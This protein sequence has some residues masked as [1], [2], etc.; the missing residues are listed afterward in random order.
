MASTALRTVRFFGTVH[1][2]VDAVRRKGAD[3]FT[4]ER[5]PAVLATT[6]V[7]G[8]LVGWQVM[9]RIQSASV[10]FGGV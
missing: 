6:C 5:F 7:T 4:P 1:A 8:L 9:D 10:S 3:L 2:Q